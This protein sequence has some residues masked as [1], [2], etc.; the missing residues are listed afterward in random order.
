[1][2]S[3]KAM[4]V[5]SHSWE[6]IPK[7]SSHFNYHPNSIKS[8]QNNGVNKTHISN[9]NDDNRSIINDDSY[10]PSKPHNFDATLFQEA[11]IVCTTFDLWLERYRHTVMIVYS[12]LLSFE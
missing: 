4:I 5:I 2:E 10:S 11:P 12:L 3:Y 1:V 6:F 7:G 9:I 8:C